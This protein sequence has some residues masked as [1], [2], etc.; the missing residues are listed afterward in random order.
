M[1]NYQRKLQ[2]AARTHAKRWRRERERRELAA[3][4]RWKAEAISRFHRGDK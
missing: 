4:R 3:I 2:Y 1:K